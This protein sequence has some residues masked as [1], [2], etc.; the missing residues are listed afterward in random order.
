MS[1]GRGR[2]ASATTPGE[3][4]SCPLGIGLADASALL[5][6]E[7]DPILA[8]DEAVR[9]VVR[10]QAGSRRHCI[11]VRRV[12]DREAEF[13]PVNPT[14]GFGRRSDRAATVA[15]SARPMMTAPASAT[16]RTPQLET[17]RPPTS[18]PVAIP[19][20]GRGSQA[21]GEVAAAAGE[22]DHAQLQGG[23][24]E[25]EADESERRG[26]PRAYVQK[27]PR[28]WRAITRPFALPGPAL[29]DRSHAGRCWANGRAAMR[30]RR[31]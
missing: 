17:T 15:G 20:G 11:F 1:A 29:C 8:D 6:R 7:H 3:L 4:K 21:R 10:D 22:L 19:A 14:V 12:S 23:A 18:A 31:S 28:R 16:P 13:T 26:A 30:R 9:C 5:V 24:D 27:P 25:P 2:P